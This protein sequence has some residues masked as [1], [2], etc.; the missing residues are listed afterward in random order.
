MANQISVKVEG[1]E[2]AIAALK[3]Y[4]LVKRQAVEDINKSTGFQI[5]QTAKGLCPVNFGRLMNSISTNWSGSGLAEGKIGGK[6]QSGDGVKQPSGDKG[7][8]AVVGTNVKYGPYVEFGTSAH[9]PPISALEDWAK[10]HGFESAWP[11]ALAIEKRGTIA[12]PYLYPAYF[13]HKN[14]Y[15]KRIE[16]VLKKDERL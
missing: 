14:K 5:E 7:M 3:K 1:V 11:I 9:F 15:L 10:K 12:S 16:S 6:A 8:V 4:Q 2:K 13:Q